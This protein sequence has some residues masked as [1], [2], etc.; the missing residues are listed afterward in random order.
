VYHLQ[1]CAEPPWYDHCKHSASC[2][3]RARRAACSSCLQRIEITWSVSELEIVLRYSALIV[4]NVHLNEAEGHRWRGSYVSRVHAEGLTLCRILVARQRESTHSIHGITRQR[5]FW[6]R[7]KSWFSKDI[8]R[9]LTALQPWVRG[10][11]FSGFNG[12][13]SIC[14]LILHFYEIQTGIP[15]L[16]RMWQSGNHAKHLT[17][18][19]CN[20]LGWVW[21]VLAII[22]ASVEGVQPLDFCSLSCPYW[23]F[24]PRIKVFYHIFVRHY[25]VTNTKRITAVVPGYTRI[26]FFCQDKASF[27]RDIHWFTGFRCFIRSWGGPTWS[28]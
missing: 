10:Y 15:C 19:G 6:S 3:N 18:S 8:F 12:V 22:I 11:G 7:V 9:S 21:P 5:W 25:S 28:K 20:S 17:I 1:V 27:D 13:C 23:I 14:W 16:F 24:G 26:F 4:S 2:R